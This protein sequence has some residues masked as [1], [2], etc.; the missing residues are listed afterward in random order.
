MFCI[1][2]WVL[3]NQVFI[4]QMNL[5]LELEGKKI[6]IK[7]ILRIHRL[8]QTTF[9]ASLLLPKVR[10]HVESDQSHHTM[11]CPRLPFWSLAPVPLS[12]LCCRTQV[13]CLFM[14]PFWPSS[15][16]VQLQ[17][18]IQFR[19]NTGHSDTSWVWMVSS[20]FPS[21]RYFPLADTLFISDGSKNISRALF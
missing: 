1:I 9:L 21:T 20:E 12:S 4:I 11:S 13:L 15:C 10:S 5:D 2:C 17:I 7:M 8:A 19:E 14:L 6:T 18:S 3:F 16:R